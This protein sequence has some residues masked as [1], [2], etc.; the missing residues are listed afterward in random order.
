MGK[1]VKV[2]GNIGRVEGG[3]FMG[4]TFELDKPANQA[5]I[6]IRDSSG[7][8]VRTLTLQNLTKG[9]HKI[10]WDAKNDQGEQVPDGNYKI[11]I[12]LNDG[13]DQRV[14]TPEVVGRITSVVFEEGK[15]KLKV[16]EDLTINLEDL[17]EISWR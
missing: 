14:I 10:E 5:L 6:T 8:I 2:N 7:K 16:N 11:S 15:A 3:Q 9:R 17:K 13:T 12:T 4:A 1:V